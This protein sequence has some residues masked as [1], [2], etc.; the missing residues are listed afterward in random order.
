M[1]HM[2]RVM[3]SGLLAWLLVGLLGCQGAVNPSYK[4]VQTPQVTTFD[5]VVSNYSQDWVQLGVQT[6]QQGQ[7]G[8]LVI[9]NGGHAT[10]TVGFL[11]TFVTLSGVTTWPNPS[12]YQWPPQTQLLGR[13][14]F[15]TSTEIGFTIQ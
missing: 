4:L 2:S 7:T 5:V 11:P 6:N 14:Y 10:F 15:D 1:R 13:D 12:L 3:L 8:T 9:P